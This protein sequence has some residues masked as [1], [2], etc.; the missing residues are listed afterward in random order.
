MGVHPNVWKVIQGFIDSET[1]TKRTLVANAAGKDLHLN[2]GR[3]SLVQNQYKR[4]ASIAQ[5]FHT[6]P[7][8]EYVNLIAHELS[9]H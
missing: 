6:L 9:L 1:E 3:R 4:I 7:S 5:Q 2:T 8:N